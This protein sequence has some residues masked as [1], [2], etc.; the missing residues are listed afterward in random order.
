MIIG[1]TASGKTKLATQMACKL[2]GEIISADSRQVYT[3]LNIGAGKD[4]E[5]YN[6]DGN[7]IPYHLIN[8]QSIK[9]RFYLKDFVLAVERAKT[10]IISKSKLP[11]VCGGTGLYLD[12]L[13]KDFSRIYIPENHELRCELESLQKEELLNR[14]KRFDAYESYN[15]DFNSKKRLI[16]AIEIM[17]HPVNLEKT[18]PTKPIFK[19]LIIGIETDPNTRKKRI[20][21]R[22]ISRINSGMIEEVE[23]LLKNSYEPESLIFLGLEYKFVTEYLIGKYTKE[24]MIGKLEIAIHQFSKRQCTWFRKMEKEGFVIHWINGAESIE[25]QIDNAMKVI[26]SN[27]AFF[28]Q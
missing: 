16:R 19:P 17:C 26:K 11:I 21:E 12:A 23:A 9:N 15:F 2:E 24:E 22:L 4:L 1:A 13:L 25:E 3:E 20:S 10:E 28:N 7:E 6:I 27:S 8:V 18:K 5:E 14:L